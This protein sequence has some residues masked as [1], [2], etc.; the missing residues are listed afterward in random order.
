MEEAVKELQ[1]AVKTR[2]RDGFCKVVRAPCLRPRLPAAHGCLAR[3][4]AHVS[5]E[6]SFMAHS[7]RAVTALLSRMQIAD[8]KETLGSGSGGACKSPY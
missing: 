1:A 6:E 2:D 4:L 7:G 8:F 3:Q 5:R